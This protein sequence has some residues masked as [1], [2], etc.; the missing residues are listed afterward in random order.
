MSGEVRT[1]QG[2]VSGERTLQRWAAENP[3]A[4]LAAVFVVLFLTTGAI[5]PGFFSVSGVRNTLLQAAPLGILA[6]AQTVLML[7]GGIDLSVTMIATGAAYVTANQSPNGA[8]I[9][10]LMGLLV[11]LIIGSVNGVGVAVFRVNPLIM[12]LAMSSILLGLFTAWT[13]TVLAGSTQVAPFI[14]LLGGGSW[15][16]SVP[17][18]VLVWGG[19][20]AAIIWLLRRS[21]WGRLIY[22]IGDNETA[23]RLAGV[24]VWQVRLTAYMLSGLLSAI[25]GILLAGRTG[26]VDLQLASAFLL[27]SVA[28]AVIG[29]TSI[30]GGMGGYSGTI[31]GALILSVLNSLL[32]FLNVGQAIQQMV[33]GS[34]V[35][36]LAWG[37]ASLTRR[38]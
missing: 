32:T 20:A 14:R 18:S 23:A 17:Y 28:A 19:V 16:G 4:I 9:A 36:A 27:P 8:A 22:A 6:A 5:Q 7:T 30:F 2:R 33:Y 37:Y 3:L 38:S 13:Q 1:A 25:A 31:L 12:T 15:M 26:A 35:L 34:I 29:G 10:I 21:G 24:R 11:G